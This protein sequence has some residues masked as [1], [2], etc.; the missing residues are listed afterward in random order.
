[1]RAVSALQSRPAMR[2]ATSC[3]VAMVMGVQRRARAGREI[4]RLPAIVN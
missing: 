4:R 1:M 3:A 2:S